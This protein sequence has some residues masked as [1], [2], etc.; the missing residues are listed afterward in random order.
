MNTRSRQGFSHGWIHIFMV[1]Y[2]WLTMRSS[3]IV[4][5]VIAKAYFEYIQYVY[6]KANNNIIDRVIQANYIYNKDEIVYGSNSRTKRV[7]S[8]QVLRNV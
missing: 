8:V 1:I 5:R 7:I 4:N 2:S 3:N 6:D